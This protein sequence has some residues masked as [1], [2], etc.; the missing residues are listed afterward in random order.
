MLRT[1]CEFLLI[2]HILFYTFPYC[3]LFYIV[4]I[5]FFVSFF[6]QQ[7]FSS[8]RDYFYWRIC[9]SEFAFIENHVRS[10]RSNTRKSV[11]SGYP[12]PAKCVEKRGRR[13]SFVIA[14]QTNQYLKRKLR[15]NLASFYASVSSHIQTPSRC[16]FPLCFLHELLLSLRLLNTNHR[17]HVYVHVKNDFDLIT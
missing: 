9:I 4:D 15:W 3:Q 7:K 5:T 17:W 1:A 16:W 10:N 8:K 13:P 12:N 14:S 2:H 11:S 6:F